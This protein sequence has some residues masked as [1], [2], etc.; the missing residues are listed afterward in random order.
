MT[1]LSETT[2]TSETPL[3]QDLLSLLRYWL[4]GRRG[5]IGLI[6]LAVM[7]GAILN[8]GWLVALG[9]APLIL[10]LLP[11]A[12]MCALGLCMSKMMGNSSCASQQ[13]A[14]KN[15]GASQTGQSETL[16]QL[17]VDT[18]QPDLSEGNRRVSSE[19]PAATAVVADINPTQTMKAKENIHA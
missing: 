7:A 8:W 9:I 14:A 10:A 2:K 6:T 13:D 5:L 11:C 19:S 17:A 3:T 18:A 12:A 16:S 1:K 15:T 4:G